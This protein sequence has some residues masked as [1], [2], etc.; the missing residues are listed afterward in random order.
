MMQPR[1]VL[2]A[3]AT[4]LLCGCAA[5]EAYNFAEMPVAMRGVMISGTVAIAVHDTRRQV[6]SGGVPATEMRDALARALKERGAVLLPVTSPPGEANSAARA[7]LLETKAQRQV[8]VT[9]REWKADKSMMDTNLHYDVTV[10]VFDQA[11]NQLA[12]HSLKG[13]DELGNLGLSPNEATAKAM[14]GKLDALFED[15]RITGALR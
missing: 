14:A 7:R 15:W 4:S 5:N 13:K 8:L 1:T 10:A 6:P 3:I 9:L 2:A 11:G 12:H